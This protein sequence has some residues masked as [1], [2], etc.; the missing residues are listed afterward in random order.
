MIY[1]TNGVS[2]YPYPYERFLNQMLDQE[3]I[4]YIYVKNYS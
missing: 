1:S 3:F 2:Y 4:R